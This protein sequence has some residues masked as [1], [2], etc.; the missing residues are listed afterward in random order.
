MGFELD[1]FNR[2]G[3][4]GGLSADYVEWLVDEQSVNIQRHFGRLWDYYANP[5]VDACGLG[6]CER[7]VSESGR[8][9]V[10]AQEYGLPA[11]ITGLLAGGN[12]GLLGARPVKDIQRKEVVIENDIAWRVNAAV[13]FLFGKPVSFVSKSPDKPTSEKIERILKALFAANGGI[14]FFQDMAVLG[15]VYGF[16][17][18]FVRPGDE[19][20]SRA[21][22]SSSY[23]QSH[24]SGP[25][26]GAIAAGAFDEVLRLAESID[27]ELVE[28]PR[29][30]PVLDED[31]YKITRYYV[32][33]FLQKRNALSKA[34]SFLSRI[35]AGGKS[36]VD[37]RATVAVTEI[38]SPAGWQRYEDKK[39]AASGEL[40]WGFLPVVHIQNIA[41]PYYYEGLSEV[42]PLIPMQDELNTRL[43][44]RAS[45]IT[46]QSFK[47]YLGK[48]IEGFENKPVAPGRM[49]YTDNPDAC[50][51]EFGGDTA[52]PSE[53]L[54][55]S[56]VREAMDKASGVTP[57]VAGI[58]KGKVGNLT[59]AV[60][61]RLTL[62]GML[63][64]NE[65]KKFTYSEG[66][67]K[68]CRMVLSMLDAAGI[69]K[70]AAADRDI[71]VV[72]PNPLPE[73]MTEKLQEARIKKELGVPAEQILREL[74]YEQITED[75]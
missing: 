26:S 11:R 35:L 8:C 63:S 3:G 55:I 49:W 40:P 31:D 44:D 17:D 27:L 13:D 50:I 60:A 38:T 62:M 64:K 20:T 37:T 15:S 30:L 19:I 1:I 42:E 6:A 51:E 29:A 61:L 16:V 5:A 14:S 23:S 54:H 32:Q 71:D 57:V 74:G 25:G 28:A 36:R 4:G 9:Y 59:S 70:T 2:A 45:R 69:F 58:L 41:Q 18:C 73:N 56:E 67:K 22:P 72:F 24:S 66:L 52:A 43:S 39:L 12:S 7:K 53:Q 47:M 10:Q 48:G 21:F 34:S 75:R 65:R 33:H 68:L 46:F